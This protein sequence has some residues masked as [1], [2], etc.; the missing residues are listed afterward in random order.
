LVDAEK[1]RFDF[2]WSTGL[3]IDEI[4]AIEAIVVDIIKTKL[5]VDSSIVPLNTASGISSLRKVFGEAYPDPVRVISVGALVN[6]LVSDPTNEQWFNSS[7]EFCGGTHLTNTSQAEDFV[8]VEESGIAKGIRRIVAF[9][10][11]QAA[12]AR[13]CATVLATKLKDA[14]L[15]P[16]SH[17]LVLAYKD[18][19]REVDQAVVSLVDKDHMREELTRLFARIKVFNKSQASSKLSNALNQAANLGNVMHTNGKDILVAQ[20]DCGNDARKIHEKLLETNP[21]ASSF[22]LYL[23]DDMEKIKCS[24]TVNPF[25]SSKN[26]N[27]K[28]W[29]DYC[30]SRCSQGKGGGRQETASAVFPFSDNGMAT[31]ASFAEEHVSQIGSVLLSL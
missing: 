23:D 6:D 17:E 4:S 3:T 16:D 8:I 20:L 27:A 22:L 1:L 7:V 2:S 28:A 29:V 11:T 10:K 30:I 9:T 31:I 19:R 24:V 5:P 14:E 15:L 21:N 18:L 26:L 12:V 25:H 13:R